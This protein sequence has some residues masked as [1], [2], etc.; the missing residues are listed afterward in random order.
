MQL[1]IFF[2]GITTSISIP[3]LSSTNHPVPTGS[4]VNGA[5]YSVIRTTVAIAV[6]VVLIIILVSSLMAYFIVF[7]R[8]RSHL[9]TE[10][11]V[12]FRVCMQ[13]YMLLIMSAGSLSSYVQINH[14]YSTIIAL[15]AIDLAL[16]YGVVLTDLT[17]LLLY[18][19]MKYIHHLLI[20]LV[21]H[22]NKTQLFRKCFCE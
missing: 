12:S 1:L 18:Y 3:F 10:C 22:P 21:F 17:N 6:M 4:Y 11:K 13:L 5:D 20:C 16:W 14:S 15:S 8:K 7:K 9:S 2:L 19:T